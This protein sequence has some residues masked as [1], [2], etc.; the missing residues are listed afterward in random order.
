MPSASRTT[1]P[2]PASRPPIAAPARPA[3]SVDRVYRAVTQRAVNWRF[4]PGERINEVA[5]AGELGV[6]RTPVREALNRLARDGFVRFVPN[7]GF[8]ARDLTPELVRDLYELRAAIE[9]AAVRLACAR[10]GDEAIAKLAGA[11]HA[12]TADAASRR[13]DRLTA[14]DEAFHRGIARLS[15]NGELVATLERVNAQIRFFRRVDQ[16]LPERRDRTYREHADVL[17]CLARRD[18]RR[19]GEL[20]ERHVVLSLERAIAV[21]E[22]VVA[23]IRG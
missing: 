11:W 23:R 14:A 1:P 3:D 12:A 13:I 20:V 9:V 6:S 2:P 21:T 7:R 5:L 19:A 15:C 4:A 18:A 22:Q 10:A 8:V 17:A 16:E